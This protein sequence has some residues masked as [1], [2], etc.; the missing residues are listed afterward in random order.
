[1]NG[2]RGAGAFARSQRGAAALELA[3][4]VVVVLGLAVLFFA[5]YQR[6]E[7]HVATPRIARQ[8]AEYVSR[9]SAPTGAELDALAQYLRSTELP[10]HSLVMTI[11]SVH[12]EDDADDADPVSVEWT[13]SVTVGDAQAITKLKAKCKGRGSD[14]ALDQGE[15][16]VAVEICA[17]GSGRLAGWGGDL[18]YHYLLPSRDQTKGTAQPTRDESNG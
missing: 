9:A 10:D 11:S 2:T 12:K 8:M 16:A 4:S 14:F 15:Y 18:H 5:V 1:M 13:D 6:V 7:A 3:L 17:A